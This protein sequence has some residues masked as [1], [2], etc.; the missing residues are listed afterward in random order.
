MSDSINS[1]LADWTAA[2]RAG[3]VDALAALLAEDFVGTGPL[4]FS[5]SKP[6]WIARHRQGLSYGA[7]GLEEIQVRTY[8]QVAVVIAHHRQRGDFRGNPIPEAAAATHVLVRDGGSW[9]LG[10]AHLSFVAGTPG[11]PPVP[12][13]SAESPG[14]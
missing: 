8:D 7:F 10:V 14:A 12:G 9:R 4:G 3:D 5:L 13:P 11:A 6:D 1:F 2:E